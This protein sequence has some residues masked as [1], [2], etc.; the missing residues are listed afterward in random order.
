MAILEISVV[1]VGTG[2]T[3]LSRY[4]GGVGR[5]LER[6]GLRY[7]VHPMGTVVEGPLD[8]LL[9]L[10]RRMHEAGFSRGVSRVLTRIAIDDRRDTERPMEAKVE[11]FQ[12]AAREAGP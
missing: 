11:S 12:R 8:E 10:A 3:S 1:P 9:A 4:L 5:E 6:S 2:G 7:E